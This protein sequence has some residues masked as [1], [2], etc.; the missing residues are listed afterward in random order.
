MWE[1]SQ[2]LARAIQQDITTSRSSV[3]ELNS[4]ASKVTLDIIGIAGLGR[5]FDAVEK[6]KDPLADIYEGLL[7]PS[8]EKLIF[9]GLALA[10]DERSL[11]LSDRNVE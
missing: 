8:R 5:R 1:K 7:E 6:K 9:S 11:Q 10:V 4:W 2:S 3:V